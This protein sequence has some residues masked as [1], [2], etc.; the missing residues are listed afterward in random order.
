MS[1][2]IS[3]ICLCH[4]PSGS[5]P[6]RQISLLP[7]ETLEGVG[8]TDGRGIIST[9]SLPHFSHALIQVIKG[10]AT[11]IPGLYRLTARRRTGGTSNARYCYS[12]WLRHL[13]HAARNHLPTQPIVVAELGPGDSIGIGLAALLSGAER[14]HALDVVAYADL[15]HNLAVFDELVELFKRCEPVPGPSEFPDVHPAL[16]SYAFPHDILNPGRLACSLAQERLEVIRDSI[17]H[18]SSADSLITYVAPWFDSDTLP[19]RS[20]DLVFSQA[21]LEHVDDL[22]FVYA[23]LFRWLRPGGF[24]SHEIDFKCHGTAS[25]WNGHWLYSETLWKVIRG[26]RPYLLNRE[27]HSMHVRLVRDHGFDLVCDIPLHRPSRYTVLELAPRFRGMTEED[28]TTS[29]AFL[30]AVKPVS[31]LPG[32]R[33]P[34][35]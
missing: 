19:E 14:Y 6:D 33:P 10:L 21:V 8:N 13:I 25:E 24:M 32:T 16:D 4:W 1:V 3:S 5:R 2:W 15:T 11:C 35:P 34:S 22:P 31:L 29:S 20:L 23:A 9:S 28:L 17:L 7:L 12:V 18:P 30:Q 27:P 26:Q